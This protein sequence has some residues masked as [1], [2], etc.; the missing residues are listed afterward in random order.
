MKLVELPENQRLSIQLLWGEQK[1]E[2][3]SNVIE[4][5]DSAVYVSPYFHN[6]S[7]LELNVVQG[8][9]VICN[10]FT[11]DPSTKHRISWKNIGLTTIVRND[12]MLYCL[13]TNGYN[14]IAK[15]ADRR[16]HDR[17]IVKTKGRV[18]DGQASEG[19]DIIVHDISD[20]GISFYAPKTFLAKTHQLNICFSDTISEKT[21]DVSVECT[22]A[23]TASRA[24]NQFVGCRIKTENKDYQLY[25]FMKRLGAKNKNRIAKPEN[26][27]LSENEQ[28]EMQEELKPEN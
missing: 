9:G 4:K 24:G 15:H 25:C 27:D 17:L 6:G 23:R 11:N 10:I 21:F 22:I 8:K 14:H 26:N 18:F 3:F 5:D 12:K 13:K 2:F 7:E 1:I 28:I 19:V 20:I 16:I